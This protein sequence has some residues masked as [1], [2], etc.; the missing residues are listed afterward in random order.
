M[1]SIKITFDENSP[2]GVIRNLLGMNNSPRVGSRP[3]T[4]LDMELFKK[5]KPVRTRHHDAIHENPGL[6][7]IDVSRIF[8]LFHADENDPRNYRF[9]P[10]DFYL[11]YTVASGTEIEFRLGET[12]EHSEERF[13][14]L[15]PEDPEKWARI[16]LN[17]IRHYNEGWADG[18]HMGIKYWSVWEEPDN[19]RLFDGPFKKYLELY[20]S[21]AKAIKREF[22]S[23]KVGGPNTMGVNDKT[24]LF[25]SHCREE[26][27]AIDFA[28]FTDYSREPEYLVAKVNALKALADKYGFTETE[29]CVSE[30][31][32]GPTSWEASVT[33]KYDCF[34]TLES[35]AYTTSVLTKLQDSP[36]SCAFYYAWA[37]S[38]WGLN[39]LGTRRLL[40]VGSA[41]IYLAEMADCRSR[42]IPTVEGGTGDCTFLCG[43]TETGSVKVLASFFKAHNAEMAFQV[44]GKTKCK[45]R[46]IYDDSAKSQEIESVDLIDGKFYI[47]FNEGGCGVFMLEFE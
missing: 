14:V 41:L 47:Y 38:I 18:F 30:F 37:V 39:A 29:I 27:V 2:K 25:F 44:P 28:E 4:D 31:H 8:P 16:C 33:D 42:L 20:T 24:E 5:I 26:G 11:K 12:I 15:P 1:D 32:Y 9:K 40:P 10:T 22:P 43:E 35:A 34:Y 13:R 17:I 46:R 19:Y 6:A 21:V 45:V 7:L 36:L 23:L 3:C